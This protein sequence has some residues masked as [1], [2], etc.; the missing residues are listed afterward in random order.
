M[1]CL[2]SL[3]SF[4]ALIALAAADCKDKTFDICD[5]GNKPAFETAKGLTEAKCQQLC[6]TIYTENCKFFIFDRRDGLCQLFDNEREDYFKSCK[7]TAGT[8]TPETCDGTEECAAFSQGFCRFNGNLLENFELVV[9]AETCRLAC[10]VY[11]D[12]CKYYVFEDYGEAEKNDCQ[13]LNSADKKCDLFL[14][15]PDPDLTKPDNAVCIQE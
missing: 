6:S 11:G 13:L 5:N 15:L 12:D 8:P 14:G 2:R 7:V 1:I 4:L 3:V 10:Q 9:D